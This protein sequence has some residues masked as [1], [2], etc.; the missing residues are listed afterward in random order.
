MQL[1]PFLLPPKRP[2][3]RSSSYPQ[4]S[5]SSH[6]S[7]QSSSAAVQRS[8]SVPDLDEP[9]YSQRGRTVTMNSEDHYRKNGPSNN[10]SS[11]RMAP[12]PLPYQPPQPPHHESS[13]YDRRGDDSESKSRGDRER[14]RGGR[15]LYE[16]NGRRVFCE[17][18]DRSSSDY[19]NEQHVSSKNS[20]ISSKSNY[21]SSRKRGREVEVEEDVSDSRNHRKKY[22]R[23]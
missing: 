10:N 8:S 13:R 7:W 1:F 9:H 20:S 14:F 6:G 11:W 22:S 17:D 23:E 5:T 2:L 18:E 3:N 19:G 4:P 21:S 12:P 16:G 15:S